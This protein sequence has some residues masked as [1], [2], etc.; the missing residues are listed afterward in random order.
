MIICNGVVG[1]SL[2]VGG[3][4]HREQSFR[5]EG[6]GSGMAALATLCALVL[7]V[8]TLT[9][10]EPG[11]YTTSQ[12]IFVASASLV[13]WLVF[14]FIQTVRHRDYFLPAESQ[15]DEEIHAAPPSAR[16]AWQSAMLLIVSLLAVVGLAKALSPSI[17]QAVVAVNAPMAT[18][19][20]AI[21]MI[22]LLPETG[23]AL[24]AA[25]ADRLQSSL[26]LAV[27]SAMACIGLTVPV[28]VIFAVAMDLPLLLGLGSME[29]ALL[30]LTFVVGSIT[31]GTGRTNVMQ[32][33]IHLIIFAAF[34]FL[35]FVP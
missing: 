31:L 33:A 25:R 22:V 7:V 19:G 13:L 15:Q 12:L 30:V 34:L 29:I 27:G 9:R 28:V 24:R 20:I 2:L 16:E 6:T 17:E 18:V 23:A 14:I 11:A 10:G 3:M 8:P 32:G 21:A 35:T 5:I 1:L 4:R 26:N